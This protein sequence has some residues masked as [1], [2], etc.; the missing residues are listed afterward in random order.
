MRSMASPRTVPIHRAHVTRC[1]RFGIVR[2]HAEWRIRRCPSSTVPD[3]DLPIQARVGGGTYV[4]RRAWGASTN[5]TTDCPAASSP[6]RFV[7]FRA[8]KLSASQRKS[9]NMSRRPAISPC[10]ASPH[11][12]TTSYPKASASATRRSM[13]VFTGPRARRKVRYFRHGCTRPPKQLKHAARG[14]RRRDCQELCRAHATTVSQATT[15]RQESRASTSPAS[16]RTCG[17]HIGRRFLLQN[18]SR[19][20][21]RL[22]S[23]RIHSPRPRAPTALWRSAG[24]DKYAGC[25]MGIEWS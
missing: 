13:A 15:I 11:R 10:V 24:Q 8:S 21:A 19:P 4:D 12:S 20:C 22:R 7:E 14:W 25:K 18:H 16:D 1:G 6:A 23:P 17:W 5:T 9:N 2:C 3:P